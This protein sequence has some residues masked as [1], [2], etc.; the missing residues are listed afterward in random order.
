MPI[1]T[2]KPAIVGSSIEALVGAGEK[3]KFNVHLTAEYGDRNLYIPS[4]IV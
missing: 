1:L 3:M 4:G 2:E